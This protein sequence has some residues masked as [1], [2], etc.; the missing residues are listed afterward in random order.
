MDRPE[1]AADLPEELVRHEAIKTTPDLETAAKRL[2]DLSDRAAR[3]LRLPGDDAESKAA[4]ADK[5]A[6]LGFQP[7]DKAP[8]TADDYELD[9]PDD[10]GL[11]AD[12][13]QEI[14]RAKRQAYYQAGIGKQAAKSLLAADLKA[15]EGSAKEYT[16]KTA[17]ATKALAEKIGGNSEAFQAIQKGAKAIGIDHIL[18]TVFTGP[19]GQLYS[20]GNEINLMDALSKIGASLGEGGNTQAPGQ[21]ASA[22]DPESQ[23]GEQQLQELMELGYI[24][25]GGVD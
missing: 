19:D 24:E 17:A 7:S 4:F 10:V 25:R 8:E 9:A 23:D 21:E 2:A 15:L 11:D 5:V 12:V 13:V 22:F 16:S 1:W 18:N 20:L 3:S 6:K 14:I